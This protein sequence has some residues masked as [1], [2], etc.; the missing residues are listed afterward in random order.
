MKKMLNIFLIIT[1]LYSA[2][3]AYSKDE[4]YS[5]LGEVAEWSIITSAYTSGYI[6]DHTP[7]WTS[8]PL[9]GGTTNSPYHENTIPSSWLYAGV[10]LFSTGIAL[11]PNNSGWINHTS[12]IN[13]KGII[14]A[15]SFTYFVTALTKDIVGRK[16]P[17][18]DNFPA[19]DEIDSKKS[20][21]SGHSAISFSIA[22][23]S[24]LYVFEHIGDINNPL[25]LTGKILFTTGMASLASY[26]AYSRVEDNMH[27]VSDVV[28]GGMV[29][30]AM[31]SLVYAFQNK[32]LDRRHHLIQHVNVSFYNG[33]GSLSVSAVF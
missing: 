32:W 15:V 30:T 19:D 23:Y 20:F 18:Y 25:N 11:L 22:T 33:M 7:V 6:I 28:V 21:F 31:S 3:T 17:C 16:R 26:V 13:T 24:S 4:G 27:F 12:Y 8:K 14:E 10:G 1:I 2:N 5:T 29:G 9:I